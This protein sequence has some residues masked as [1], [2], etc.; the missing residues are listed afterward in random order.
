MVADFGPNTQQYTLALMVARPVFV[1]LAENT[2]DNWT[3]DGG[4]NL[5]QSNF[6]RSLRQEVAAPDS[7]LRSH[8]ALGL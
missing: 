1:G 7:T 4:D 6:A 2:S 5:G 8:Q 3:V